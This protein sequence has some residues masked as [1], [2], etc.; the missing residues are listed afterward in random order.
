MTSLDLTPVKS[1]VDPGPPGLMPLLVFAEVVRPHESFLTVAA[2]ELL[3]PG[4]DSL[5]AR[6]LVA[7][8]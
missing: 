4:V 3:H 2:H 8:Q 7:P 5:V 1:E 6:Q